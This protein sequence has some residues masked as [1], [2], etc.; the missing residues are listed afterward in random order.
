MNTGNPGNSEN[1]VLS[2]NVRLHELTPQA[3]SLLCKEGVT[4]KIVL[5]LITGV[6]ILFKYNWLA[7]NNLFLHSPSLRSRE[8]D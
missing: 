4:S 3:P 1:E 6:H 8:G 7:F 2:I 5:S